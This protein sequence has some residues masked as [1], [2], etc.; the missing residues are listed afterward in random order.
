MA[1]VL[2]G[3][4][5]NRQRWLDLWWWSFKWPTSTNGSVLTGRPPASTKGHF[6]WLKVAGGCLARQQ[7]PVLAARTNRFWPSV[8][9]ISDYRV[10]NR[11][12]QIMAKQVYFFLILCY[13]VFRYKISHWSKTK[14]N[15]M[16]PHFVICY[17]SNST[18]HI[19][20]CAHKMYQKRISSVTRFQQT[21][22]I[23]RLPFK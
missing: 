7:K 14:R 19:V 2:A 10:F 8:A 16:L 11:K 17:L 21:G 5:S 6:Y 23:S 1:F 18:I 22:P 20:N 12:S 4:L 9:P 13:H 15:R 3:C